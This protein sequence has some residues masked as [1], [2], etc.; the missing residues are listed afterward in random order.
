MRTTNSPLQVEDLQSLLD[1]QPQD[2]GKAFDVYYY[3]DLLLRRRW[4]VL[5]SFFNLGGNGLYGPNGA[6][7]RRLRSRCARNDGNG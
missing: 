3:I 1:N 6:V 5:V 2:Q 7:C 4:F